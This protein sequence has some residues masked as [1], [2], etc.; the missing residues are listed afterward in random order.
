MVN[1]FFP[2]VTRHTL[3][4]ILMLA[5]CLPALPAYGD[6]LE[7]DVQGLEE[8]MLGNVVARTQ[9]FRIT[10]N[11]RISRKHREKMQA[12]AERRASS[13]LRPYGY[14]HAVVHGD[15]KSAGD[16]NWVLTLHI[17]KGPP[18]IIT[19]VRVDLS[20]PGETDAGLLNWQASWPLPPGLVLD[21]VTWEEQKAEALDLAEIHGYLGARFS[22]QAIRL[23]LD[24]NTAELALVLETGDQSVMGSIVYNQDEVAVAVLESLPRFSEGQVYD[25]W[26]IEQFRLD[27][28]KTGYFNNIEVVEE[29][30]LEESP[31]RVNL[32]VNM[33]TRKRNTYQGSIG[34]GSDTGFRLQAIWNQHLLSSRGDSL[35]V[36]V[37]WQQ[38]NNQVSLRTAYRQP[39]K[40]PGQQY[41]TAELLYKTEIEEFEVSPNED[42]NRF[43]TIARGRVDDYSFKPGWLKVRSLERGYQQIFEQWYLQ[44]LKETSD[45]SLV[46]D[47]P[48]EYFALLGR[49]GDADTVNAPSES[50]S[51]GVN[52]NWPLIRGSDFETVG[53]NYRAWIFTSNT[54]WGSDIDFSQA[55][56]SGHWNKIFK[57]RWKILLRG[58]IGYTDAKIN[59]R[60][61]GT[62]DDSI[63]I[64][65]TELP[66]A[67]RFKAGGSQS[68]RGYG[69]ESLS[70]NNIG[71][72]NIIT[73]S[74]ELEMRFR[75]KWS[76]AVFVDAGNAFNE[77]SSL[78]LKKGAGVGI[79]WYS[80][81]GA[82]RVDL[83]Q[84]LDEPGKPWT[85]HFTIGSPLL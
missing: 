51:V 18:V 20:G 83:A 52:W 13:A 41:W 15:M 61:V 5:L 59:N 75:P 25:Q 6:Q 30:R 72:N 34:F 73:A 32:V 35:D 7:I 46:D 60:T 57:E 19:D 22:E 38:K 85:V 44:Y 2:G 49:G 62:G 9:S 50:L 48:A 74:A 28:W 79:R 58:E 33:E 55:Y 8:P 66:Y 4:L 27:L 77:W 10:G 17:D 24:N 43:I 39:R 78:E 31:P 40:V 45:F 11:S 53:H 37:G 21:Q 42:P 23:D 71:S 1:S 82:V 47:I 76:A 70:N 84:A 56:I 12:D 64:S 54:A 68:V 3:P 16:G 69:F 14:Y 65:V 67:Y 80:I 63:S 26:L 81:A 36:G 29:R